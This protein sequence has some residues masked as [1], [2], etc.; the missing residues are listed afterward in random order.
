MPLGHIMR[1]D[2]ERIA[3]EYVVPCLHDIGFCYLDNFLGEVVGDCVLERVKRMHRDGELADGQLAGPSRGV[4]KRH[5]RGDQIKW[6]G[7]TEEGCEAI[8]FLLTLIDR[9]VMYCG[10]RLGKYY[11]KERS[12]VRG[13]RP[14]RPGPARLA[15]AGS[16]W[17]KGSPGSPRPPPPLRVA[18]AGRPWLGPPRCGWRRRRALPRGRPRR[19]AAL[20]PV[21]A[22]AGRGGLAGNAAAAAGL[23]A[24]GPSPRRCRRRCPA[25]GLRRVPR[26]RRSPAGPST[27]APRATG[28]LLAAVPGAAG[29]TPLPGGGAGESADGQRDT[30]EPLAVTFLRR[31][32]SGGGRSSLPPPPCARTGLGPASSV[33]CARVRVLSKVVSMV[34]LVP[35]SYS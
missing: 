16:T 17:R 30:V 22:A 19:A 10:S 6:I 20:L 31:I 24:A 8:N 12:K 3:L 13:P 4:A 29:G 9:L 33:V 7:G 28:G 21:P 27:V 15:A 32:V 34:R 25:L 5:L 1:L 26:Y 2:L 11:V 18:S 23:P 35:A 14:A